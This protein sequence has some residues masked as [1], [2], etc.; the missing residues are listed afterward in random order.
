M[1]DTMTPV[2]PTIDPLDTCDR[3]ST[4]RP[5]FAVLLV[6]HEHP[7]LL[8]GHCWNTHAAAIL[9][10]EGVRYWGLD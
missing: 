10:T 4:A 1:I 9:T 6:G 5:K 8:C 2:A 7:L 3:H